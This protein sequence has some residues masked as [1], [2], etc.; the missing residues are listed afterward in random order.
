MNVLETVNSGS[1][2][3]KR[4]DAKARRKIPRRDQCYLVGMRGAFLAPDEAAR[5]W[6]YLTGFLSEM[7]MLDVPKYR[8]VIRAVRRATIEGRKSSSLRGSEP[9]R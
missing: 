4:G 7:G 1:I 8:D 3:T 9:P 5:A 6:F 2:E